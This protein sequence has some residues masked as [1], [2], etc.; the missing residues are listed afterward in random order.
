[1]GQLHATDPRLNLKDGDTIRMKEA[2]QQFEAQYV[3]QLL[4]LMA[5]KIGEANGISSGGFAEETFRPQ[6]HD[7]IAKQVVRTGGFGVAENVY[8]ELL[9][10]Q[11]RG[12]GVTITP[13]LAAQS[14]ANTPATLK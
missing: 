11:S 3:F 13:E 1:M 14:Y 10:S 8:T 7:A 6:L 5:P 12:S 2:A 4:E 9:T